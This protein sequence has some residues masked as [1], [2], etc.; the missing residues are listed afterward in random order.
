MHKKNTVYIWFSLVVS[1]F[2]NFWAQRYDILALLL[3]LVLNGSPTLKNI[4]TYKGKIASSQENYDL[5]IPYTYLNL[6]WKRLLTTIIL[7]RPIPWTEISNDQR[8]YNRY[9]LLLNNPFVF[10]FMFYRSRIEK[11]SYVF[12]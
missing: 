12:N 9:T 5:R 11:A 8:L 6:A 3:A 10:Y 4:A 1:A 7:F 2:S